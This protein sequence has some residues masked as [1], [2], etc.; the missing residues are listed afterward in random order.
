LNALGIRIQFRSAKWPE[1]LKNARAGKLQVWN[2]ARSAAS[3]DGRPALDS[4]ATA[5]KGGQNLARFSSERYDEIYQRISEMPDGPERNRLF[6][7]AKRILT[8]YAP[9]KNGVHRILTD[10]SW[11]SISGF[12]RPPYWLAWW[13]YV[14]IDVA[15]QPMGRNR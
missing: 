5:H 3:P 7:E 9:Y 12:R 15:E 8:A 11:S 1:N 14:D 2:L 6:T 4:G 10:L 13:S